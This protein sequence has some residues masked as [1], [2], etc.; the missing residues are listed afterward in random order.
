ME[1]Y[2]RPVVADDAAKQQQQAA[3]RYEWLRKA[4]VDFD[5]DD[6]CNTAL[7]PL[8][9]CYTPEEVDQA[10]DRELARIAAES[11]I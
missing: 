5:D 4:Y 3:A 2:V 10:I 1:V 8:G 11:S 9:L 6:V 7:L